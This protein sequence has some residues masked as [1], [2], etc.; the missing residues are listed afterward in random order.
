MSKVCCSSSSRSPEYV[1]RFAY[2]PTKCCTS[3]VPY[4]NYRKVFRA[5]Q[6]NVEREL[7]AVQSTSIDLANRAAG[8]DADKE[9]VLKSIDGMIGRV[10]NL[11]RKVGRFLPICAFRLMPLDSALGPARNGREAYT[12]CHA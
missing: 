1:H 12:R 5:S 8:G 11:K 3:K 10:E 2:L 7:G 9:E 6:K 4:E